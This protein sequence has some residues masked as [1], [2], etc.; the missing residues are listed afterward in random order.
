MKSPN[1][2]LS[3]ILFWITIWSPCSVQAFPFQGRDNP[4]PTPTLAWILPGAEHKEIP[5]DTNIFLAVT[6]FGAC[7]NVVG[8][9]IT[10]TKKDDPR[11]VIEHKWRHLKGDFHKTKA[12]NGG[13]TLFEFSLSKRL[14][15]N[16]TYSL[17]IASDLDAGVQ[18]I[19]E[20]TTGSTKAKRTLKPPI[21]SKLQVERFI[22]SKT[23]HNYTVTVK[24]QSLSGV[25]FVLPGKWNK[26]IS[27]PDI[28][29]PK[30]AHIV[31][32]AY[33]TEHETTFIFTHSE[34]AGEE[35][36]ATVT[37]KHAVGF[38]GPHV[39]KCVKVQL[40]KT[41]PGTTPQ[42]TGGCSCT[43]SS[44]QETGYWMISLFFLGVFLLFSKSKIKI[45][46]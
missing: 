18:N 13:L 16:T 12:D 19:S 35:K 36:C 10:I 1:H 30:N 14:D 39:S 29:I 28:T 17:D 8:Q 11:Q 37:Q 20:F 23:Q 21:I 41:P 7:D 33:K 45:S 24:S 38:W 5:T 46:S 22:E 40:T 27:A 26:I 2:K 43:T 6:T 32:P 25:L 34:Q 31:Q 44:A 15:P 4:C 3:F 42:S 9:S